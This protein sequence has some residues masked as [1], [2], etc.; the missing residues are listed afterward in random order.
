MVLGTVTNT[1]YKRDKHHKFSHELWTEMYTSKNTG[2]KGT[3]SKL[4]APTKNRTHLLKKLDF[5]RGF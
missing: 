5:I 1:F 4:T 3:F 2:S